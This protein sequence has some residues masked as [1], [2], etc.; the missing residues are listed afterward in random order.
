ME[1][2]HLSGENVRGS[3]RRQGPEHWHVTVWY[4]GFEDG[5]EEQVF[6]DLHSALDSANQ[7][8]A[9]C[10]GVPVVTAVKPTDIAE[11]AQFPEF[12]G[13]GAQPETAPLRLW[14]RRPAPWEKRRA[15][16]EEF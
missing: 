6:G 13:V 5:H 4:P 7:T 15:T 14:S 12:A 16:A 2:S 11:Q 9:A 3:G 10:L 8:P 1:E